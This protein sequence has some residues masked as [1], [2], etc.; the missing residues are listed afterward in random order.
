VSTGK[1]GK[2]GNGQT[3][4]ESEVKEPPAG[5]PDK[6]GLQIEISLPPKTSDKEPKK[7]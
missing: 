6:P 4:P 7:H 2:D 3:K 1:P 5:T